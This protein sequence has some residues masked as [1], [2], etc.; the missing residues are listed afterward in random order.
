MLE[1]YFAVNSIP[2]L[3]REL[4]TY[5]AWNLFSLIT[6]PIPLELNL[7]LLVLFSTIAIQIS[8]KYHVYS[9]KSLVLAQMFFLKIYKIISVSNLL[10]KKRF[11]YI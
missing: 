6:Y 1:Y 5:G 4:D 10:F 8:Q 9:V 2:N 3:L 7:Y 11:N